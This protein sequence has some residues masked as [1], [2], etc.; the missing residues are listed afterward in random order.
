MDPAPV[1]SACDDG[2]E[3]TTDDH[4]D[5]AGECVGEPIPGRPCTGNIQC[6]PGACIDG[7]CQCPWIRVPVPTLSAWGAVIIALLVAALGKVY[8]GRRRT[9]R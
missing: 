6:S 9:A 7:V 8:F 5:G 2:D 4:C 1:G 3:C